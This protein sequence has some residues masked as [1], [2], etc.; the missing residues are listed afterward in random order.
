MSQLANFETFG[1]G[2]PALQIKAE[3]PFY[4]GD[5]RRPGGVRGVAVVA[6]VL[7]GAA[8]G[9]LHLRLRRRRRLRLLLGGGRLL[10]AGMGLSAKFIRFGL[11]FWHDLIKLELIFN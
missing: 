7:H 1:H 4:P 8:G 5:D 11:G 6:D 9:G 3:P 2:T 10:R